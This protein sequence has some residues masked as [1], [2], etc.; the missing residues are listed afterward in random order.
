MKEKIKKVA[1]NVVL[2]LD[3]EL[4]EIYVDFKI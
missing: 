3:R 2:I 4:L 1:C